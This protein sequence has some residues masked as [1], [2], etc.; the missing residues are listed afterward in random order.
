MSQCSS[1]VKDKDDIDFDEFLENVKARQQS[2]STC[3]YN[4]VPRSSYSATL[5]QENK[6]YCFSGFLISKYMRGALLF[7]IFCHAHCINLSPTQQLIVAS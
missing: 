5:G 6:I 2:M 7:F 3:K 1:S 4:L